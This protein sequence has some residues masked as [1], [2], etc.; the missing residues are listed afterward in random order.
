[1]RFELSLPPYNLAPRNST[2]TLQGD[3]DTSPPRSAMSTPEIRNVPK[4][5]VIS[6]SAPPS[7]SPREV[8]FDGQGARRGAGYDWVQP[9]RDRWLGNVGAALERASATPRGRHAPD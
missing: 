4:P 7:S 2:L 3:L 6:G 5:P 1:M 8:I 9:N